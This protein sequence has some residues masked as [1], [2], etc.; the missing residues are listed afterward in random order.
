MRTPTSHP[1][2]PNRIELSDQEQR[3]F[4][5]IWYMLR[6]VDTSSQR[7]IVAALAT[8]VNSV[9]QEPP[10]WPIFGQ[11]VERAQPRK[12]WPLFLGNRREEYPPGFRLLYCV[13]RAGKIGYM[14][15]LQCDKCNTVIKDEENSVSIARGM[16]WNAVVLCGD[17]GVD[18]LNLHD[19]IQ[20]RNKQQNTVEK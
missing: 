2:P 12:G 5:R 11:R 6:S 13:R 20:E 1:K 9:R 16:L 7:N 8:E 14:N 10:C 3:I 18:V 19:Q 17:C 15:I 4:N